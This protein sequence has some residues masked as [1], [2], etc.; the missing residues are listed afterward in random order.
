MN[1]CGAC[2]VCCEV[3][4][5]EGLKESHKKCEHQGNGNC[6]IYKTRPKGCAHFKCVWLTSDWPK[7]FRPDKSGIMLAAVPKEIK[8]YRLK[9][10]VNQ[11]LFKLIGKMEKVKGYDARNLYSQ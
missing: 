6:S 8:A 7:E 2:Q 1:N 10:N 9:N 5:V 3:L 11:D 4:A